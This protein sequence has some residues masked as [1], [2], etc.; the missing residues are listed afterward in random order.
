MFQKIKEKVYKFFA[1]KVI[2]FV[3]KK[4]VAFGVGLEPRVRETARWAAR[5]ANE[6]LAK[7]LPGGAQDRIEKITL[8]LLVWFVEEF[9]QK[10]AGDKLH[11]VARVE[12]K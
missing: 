6:S 1:S 7:I 8:M 11:I 12:E 4:V 3:V 10:L 5:Y 2:G 9:G